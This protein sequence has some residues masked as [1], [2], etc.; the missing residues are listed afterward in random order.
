MGPHANQFVVQCACQSRLRIGLPFAA[1]KRA[2]CPKCLQLLPARS[3]VRA[4]PEYRF[5]RRIALIFLIVGIIPIVWPPGLY[6][7]A[8]IA[9]LYV[10][11]RLKL[12][13]EVRGWAGSKRFFKLLCFNSVKGIQELALWVS[14]GILI[15][16]VVQFVLRAFFVVASDARVLSIESKLVASQSF[17]SHRLTLKWVVCGLAF[18]LLIAIIWPTSI[19][20]S[21]FQTGRKWIGHTVTLLTV[22]TSFSF[23]SAR[24]V[25]SLEPSWV[26]GRRQELAESVKRIRNARQQL[27]TDAYLQRQIKRLSDESKKNLV[28][29]FEN[30]R[31]NEKPVSD[32]GAEILKSEPPFD[33]SGNDYPDAE[34]PSN[35]GPKQPGGPPPATEPGEGGSANA[36][37]QSI[38]RTDDWV[39]DRTPVAPALAD[40]ERVIAEAARTET[41]LEASKSAL[42]ESLKTAIGTHWIPAFDP[43]AKSFISSLQ[44][45]VIKT[46]VS[47]LMPRGV[48]SVKAAL[49]WVAKNV[50]GTGQAQWNPPIGT[51]EDYWKRQTPIISKNEPPQL[52]VREPEVTVPGSS[53]PDGLPGLRRG[54]VETP[55]GNQPIITVDSLIEH[56]SC[57]RENVRLA[58]AQVLNQKGPS[59]TASEVGKIVELLNDNSDRYRISSDKMFYDTAPVR[60]YAAKALDGMNSRY[61]SNSSRRSAGEIVS[62]FDTPHYTRLA[63]T[64]VLK[65][66]EL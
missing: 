29:Y 43:L 1:D 20:M 65:A 42:T 47:K 31:G 3:L 59:L 60:F 52:P 37:E 38:S 63:S 55:S 49:G 44:S 21:Q 14:V 22:I 16:C 25:A 56:L 46:S 5:V 40:G 57:N 26:A 66:A 11:T 10:L 64:R 24:S 17:L 53:F 36:R 6:L 2:R 12:G 9:L 50:P 28:I 8:A 45:S 39:N 61:L 18:W 32:L 51:V 13:Q 58:V 62:R 33:N 19:R 35:G 23:F 54:S 30:S 15:V 48:T 7:I 34:P 41:L 4:N 27:V